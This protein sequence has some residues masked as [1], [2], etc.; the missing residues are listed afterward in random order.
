M[1]GRLVA[2][3]A[4]SV[5]LPTRAEAP[6]KEG[7][8]AA[9]TAM[10]LT[11]A[12]HSRS[13]LVSAVAKIGGT[14]TTGCDHRGPKV[15]ADCPVTDL[16]RLL[17]A[18]A[19]MLL[20]FEPTEASF[21]ACRRRIAGERAVEDHDP[22]ALANRLLSES[23][24]AP[25]SRYARPVGGTEES[26]RTLTRHDVAALY[27]TGVAPP[28]MTVVVVGDLGLVDAEAAVHES[29]VHHPKAVCRPT[30]DRQP[31]PG[32]GPRLILRPGQGGGQTQIMMGCFAV[33]RLDPRWAS[34]RAA[35]KILGGGADALLNKEL[36]GRLGISYGFEARF[37]PY[38]SGGLFMV[39]GSVDGTHSQE[40][41]AAVLRVIRQTVD[42]GVDARLFE[43]VRTHMVTGAAET[44][45]TTLAV[46]QQHTELIS[47]GIDEAFIDRHL[48][49]LRNLD[50]AQM[51]SDLRSLVDPDRLHVAVVGR[52][53]PDASVLAGLER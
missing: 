48:E 53:D 17:D 31:E 5:A 39:A 25:T 41:A 44:Y 40:A 11:D 19:T 10:M 20:R 3:V 29:F 50:R 37:V 23:V 22:S 33:D 16:P 2:T 15:V 13:G 45:E 7:A 32:S 52:F 35:A 36:R 27:A 43:R 28:T 21:E 47:C 51:E 49:E 9:Y 24:L 12:P 26:W 6:D 30:A 8:V 4:V 34:A 38:F 1:P 42:D 18:L 46:A 14:I